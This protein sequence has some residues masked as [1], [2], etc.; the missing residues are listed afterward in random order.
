MGFKAN[1][2]HCRWEVL[3]RY[4]VVRGSK[5]KPVCNNRLVRGSSRFKLWTLV[6]WKG[7]LQA[8]IQQFRSWGR[9]TIVRVATR[10]PQ[11]LTQAGLP[12]FPPSRLPQW[13]VTSPGNPA[14][15]PPSSSPPSSLGP[16]QG[17]RETFST[18]QTVGNRRRCTQLSGDHVEEIAKLSTEARDEL[19]F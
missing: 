12:S 18:E 15:K 8:I 17:A 14:S 5:H 13:V 9:P 11:W 7:T 19:V 4:D 3:E 2:L 1:F 16:D 6:R 10:N